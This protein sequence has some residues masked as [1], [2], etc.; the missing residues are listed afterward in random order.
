MMRCPL[1]NLIT[2]HSI[3]HQTKISFTFFNIAELTFGN[4]ITSSSSSIPRSFQKENLHGNE[5]EMN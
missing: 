5:G 4:G 2:H 1:N 3:V